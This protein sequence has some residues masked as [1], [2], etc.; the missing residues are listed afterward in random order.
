MDTRALQQ[1]NE[2]RKYIKLP[3]MMQPATDRIKGHK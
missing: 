3:E 2:E 1:L